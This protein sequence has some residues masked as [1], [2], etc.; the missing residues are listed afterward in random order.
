[1]V[2]R[3]KH[4]RRSQVRPIHATLLI[5]LLTLA[6]CGGSAAPPSGPPPEFHE[7]APASIVIYAGNGQTGAPGVRLG[8]PLC[9]NVLDG[10]GRKLHGV[11]VTYTVTTGGG[12]L[13]DPT[14]PSTDA[15]GIATSGLWTLGSSAGQQ[16]VTASVPG[17]PSVTFTATAH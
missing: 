7:A 3:S 10:Q 6:G 8:D 11:A 15:S 4:P 1:M 5:S 17:I 12:S 9:T 2:A 13:A 14:T 16:S